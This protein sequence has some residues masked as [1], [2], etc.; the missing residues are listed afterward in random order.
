MALQNSQR[1]LKLMESGHAYSWREFSSCE[2][3]YSS[4]RESSIAQECNP[5]AQPMILDAGSEAYIDLNKTYDSEFQVLPSRVCENKHQ[6][7]FNQ[8]GEHA[9]KHQNSG[10]GGS[11]PHLT[12]DN[13]KPSLGFFSSE[14]GA[15]GA[16][17][18]EVQGLK[19]VGVDEDGKS[20]WD[21]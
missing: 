2:W 9:Y 11:K 16:H 20:Q 6:E 7:G 21:D 4:I 19:D 12:M 10:M 17:T 5:L 14:K 3:G 8:L 13:D 15:L 1:K 18:T